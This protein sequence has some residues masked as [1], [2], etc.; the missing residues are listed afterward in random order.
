MPDLL[1]WPACARASQPDEAAA[2][3]AD[4]EGAAEPILADSVD[5]FLA[6]VRQQAARGDEGAEA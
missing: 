4:E 6:S 5:D 2:A 3:A 1:P